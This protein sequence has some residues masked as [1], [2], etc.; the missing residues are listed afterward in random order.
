[1]IS[2]KKGYSIRFPEGQVRVMGRSA[3]GVKG[4]DLRSGDEVVGMEIIDQEATILTVCERGFGKRTDTSE[5]R[6]QSRGGKGII[7]IK[8][9]D[10]NGDVVGSLLV[11]EEDDC[12]LVTDQ[13]KIIRIEMKDVRVIGRNTK[14]VR[15]ITCEPDE[16]VVATSR[17]V[18]QEDE[19]DG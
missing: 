5:Y 1:M 13:G 8:V 15:L 4:I 9:D 17:L 3:R 7:T 14:G 12:M 11:K 19:A 10:R 6:D 16:R 2:S 18:E